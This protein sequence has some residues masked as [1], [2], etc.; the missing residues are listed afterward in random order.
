MIVFY[1]LF[2]YEIECSCMFSSALNVDFVFC[3]TTE[4][5]HKITI[6]ELCTGCLE[7]QCFNFDLFEKNKQIGYMFIKNL[8]SSVLPTHQYD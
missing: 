4:N 5:S 3:R 8:L 6:Y 1:L 2:C 7:E